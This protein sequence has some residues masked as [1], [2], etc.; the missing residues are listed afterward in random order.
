MFIYSILFT[1]PVPQMY[2]WKEKG[3][4]F[5]WKTKGPKPSHVLNIKKTMATLTM[6]LIIIHIYSHLSRKRISVEQILMKRQKA[7]LSNG[8]LTI[9]MVWEHVQLRKVH[10]LHDFIRMKWIIKHKRQYRAKKSCV[11]TP[12]SSFQSIRRYDHHLIAY[13]SS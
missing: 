13:Q 3:N 11:N 6:T 7:M 12:L 8:W 5:N 9:C 2:Y 10:H 1:L 4:D